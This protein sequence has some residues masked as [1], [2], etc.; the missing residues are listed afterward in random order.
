MDRHFR[1]ANNICYDCHQTVKIGYKRCEKHLLANNSKALEYLKRPRGKETR[2]KYRSTE[3]FKMKDLAQVR[4]YKRTNGR[5]SSAT[6]YARNR[7]KEWSLSKEEYLD[8]ISKPCYYCNLTNDVEV[9]VGL[10]RID[11]SK[12]YITGNC[13]SCCALCNMTRGDRFSVEEM[14]QIGEVIRI[15]KQKRI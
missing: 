11:N 6:G 4:K 14:K 1:A 5:Y 7:G 12:G 13:L 9:G 3:E 15:I 8:L 10:D 2:H